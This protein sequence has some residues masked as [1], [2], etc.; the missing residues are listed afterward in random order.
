MLF[1]LTQY[2]TTNIEIKKNKIKYVLGCQKKIIVV[3]LS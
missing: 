1:T 2:I 3:I